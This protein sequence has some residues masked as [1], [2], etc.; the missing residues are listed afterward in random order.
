MP[1]PVRLRAGGP[2]DFD[3][4][5][6][7]WREASRLGHPFLSEADLDAQERL[8]RKEH[9][10]R[11]DL[12]LAE[13]AG[14]IVGF[15]A[16]SGDYIGGLFVAPEA[17]RSGVGRSLLEHVRMRSARFRLGVYE[18]NPSARAFYGRCGFVQIGRSERDDEGRPLPV[19]ELSWPA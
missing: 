15:I 3:D 6:R 16:T 12:V 9:L 17:Q 1:E 11:A 19:I 2:A 18:A 7:V 14:R 5:M 10:P 13:R 4:V 8:T